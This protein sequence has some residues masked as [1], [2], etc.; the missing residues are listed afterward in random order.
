MSLIDTVLAGK[1]LSDLQGEPKN[2]PA[3]QEPELK[4]E[5]IEKAINLLKSGAKSH[6]E[7]ARSCNFSSAQI[8]KIRRRMNVRIAELV[9][10]EN[11]V[12]PGPE[13][14]VIDRD[15]WCP[16]TALACYAAW[17]DIIENHAS[18]SE[19]ITKHHF[20]TLVVK[21]FLAELDRVKNDLYRMPF[22]DVVSDYLDKAAVKSDYNIPDYVEIVDSKGEVGKGL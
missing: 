21:A 4:E 18:E 2:A 14:V 10:L 7:M 6:V 8:K 17:R 1:T 3:N 13:P 15:S 11:P 20:D 16:E 12:E 9:A 19:M 5:K 22:D